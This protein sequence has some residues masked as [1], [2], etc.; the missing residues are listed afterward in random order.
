MCHQAKFILKPRAKRH[1]RVFNTLPSLLSGLLHLENALT[2]L[3]LTSGSKFRVWYFTPLA[4]V[5]IKATWEQKTKLKLTQRKHNLLVF[6]RA[7]ANT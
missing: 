5:I 4:E 3:V 2:I 1:Y 6:G 7:L